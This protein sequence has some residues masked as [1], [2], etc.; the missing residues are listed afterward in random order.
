MPTGKKSSDVQS[1]ES[2]FNFWIIQNSER[3]VSTK[4]WAPK[5]KTMR[6]LPDLK[7]EM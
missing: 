6:L 3:Q 5:L 2:A 4:R 7:Q 1:R